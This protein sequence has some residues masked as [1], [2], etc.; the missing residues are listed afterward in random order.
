MFG[1]GSMKRIVLWLVVIVAT[2]FVIAGIVLESSGIVDNGSG[3]R[4]QTEDDRNGN[5]DLNVERFFNASE[6]DDIYVST[7]STDVE[8]IPAELQEVRIHFYGTLTLKN[9]PVPEL[10]TEVN[11]GRLKIQIKH[12]KQFF[13]GFNFGSIKLN[14]DIYVPENYSDNM[15]FNTVSG[16]VDITKF[17]LDRVDYNSVSGDLD[18]SGLNTNE[19]NVN[20]T[21]GKMTADKFSGKLDYYSVSGNMDVEYNIFNND[22]RTNT[23]SGNVKIRLPE[24]SKFSL[25]FDSVSGKINCEFPLTISGTQKKHS[26]SGKVGESNNEIE[27]DSVSGDARIY[28]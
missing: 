25:E 19:T 14:L 16:D 2:S 15:G 27:I 13:T 9:R 21:S 3:E 6:I 20:T 11:N 5:K 7:V 4:N 28:K 26:I 10:I 22:I 18:I 8:M 24:N 17:N 23:T 12:K 1:T